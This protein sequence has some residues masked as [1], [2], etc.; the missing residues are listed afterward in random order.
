MCIIDKKRFRFTIFPKICYKAF[1][2]NPNT[3]QL[4]NFFIGTTVTSRILVPNS[5]DE[6]EY[7]SN[8]NMFEFKKGFIHALQFKPIS[9]TGLHGTFKDGTELWVLKCIIPPFTRYAKWDNVSICSRK[10]IIIDKLAK[11][12]LS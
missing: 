9:H 12:V 7:N 1:K 4:T 10:M 11:N 6:P 8:T 3:H 5:K 2:Y